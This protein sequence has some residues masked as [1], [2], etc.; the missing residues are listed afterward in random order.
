LTYD[1][2]RFAPP[3]RVLLLVAAQGDWWNTPQED[4]EAL[5]PQLSSLLNGNASVTLLASFDDDYFMTG[6]PTTVSFSMYLIYE[7]DDPDAIVGLVHEVRRSAL[8]R[9]FRV[10]ARLG[11]Q[12]FLVEK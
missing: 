12:L 1:R 6:N 7:V 4:R 10:E 11:R 8:A 2:P 3:H 9:F 5:L